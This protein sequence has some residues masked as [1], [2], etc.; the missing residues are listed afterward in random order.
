[1]AVLPFCRGEVALREKSFE[2]AFAH[3]RPATD[4]RPPKNPFAEPRTDRPW[5]YS[6]QQICNLRHREQ[7]FHR[8]LNLPQQT[9]L[10]A[11]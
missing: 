11:T 3:H 4:L 9:Y 6:P 2:L 5:A 8:H 10:D 7:F 1:M